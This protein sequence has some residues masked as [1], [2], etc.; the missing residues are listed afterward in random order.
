MLCL[1]CVLFTAIAVT[2]LVSAD[3]TY[4]LLTIEALVIGHFTL[5][6]FTGV[7]YKMMCLDILETTFI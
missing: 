2:S 6:H 4:N 1:C 7:I 5:I 3:H